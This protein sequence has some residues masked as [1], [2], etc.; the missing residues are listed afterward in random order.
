MNNIISDLHIHHVALV[1]ENF[2]A[3]IAFYEKLGFVKYTGWGEGDKRIVLMD[4][5]NG[6]YLEIF[7]SNPDSTRDGGR[8][9]HLAFAVQDVKAAY[10]VAIAAGAVSK[11]APKVVPVA[12]EPKRITI[13]CAFVIGLNGETLEFFKES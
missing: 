12:S 3:T 7:A 8:F 9:V 5:G 6:S 11:I 13:N 2:E 10:D 1:A 4:M